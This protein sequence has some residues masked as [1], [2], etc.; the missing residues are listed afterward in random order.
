MPEDTFMPA[1]TPLLQ[2]SSFPMNIDDY[3]RK[4]NLVVK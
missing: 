3:T 4:N 2:N 1:N